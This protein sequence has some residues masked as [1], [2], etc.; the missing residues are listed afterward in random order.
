MFHDMFDTFDTLT[1]LCSRY[2]SSLETPTAPYVTFVS[3]RVQN[4][5]R[6]SKNFKEVWEKLCRSF[7]AQEARG[8]G[9]REELPWSVL[10]DLT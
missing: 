9:H 1:I 8:I 7:K 10:H 2:V 6:N 5:F 3:T 4:P